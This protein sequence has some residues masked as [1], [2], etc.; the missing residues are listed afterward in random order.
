MHCK[1]YASRFTKTAYILKRREYVIWRLR[2]NQKPWGNHPA[3][4]L[5]LEGDD[6]DEAM[7]VK[8]KGNKNVG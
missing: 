8:A 3:M 5:T 2:K 7:K 6:E 1:I 4:C